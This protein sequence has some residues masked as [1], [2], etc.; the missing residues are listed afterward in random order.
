MCIRDRIFLGKYGMAKE[1]IDY[2]ISAE[3]AFNKLRE[4]FKISDEYSVEDARKIL[5]VRNEIAELGYMMY[6][7]A[8]IATDISQNSLSL[9]HI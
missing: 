3:E 4:R 8:T 6:M 2:D 5:V 1:Q 9:I 7:S